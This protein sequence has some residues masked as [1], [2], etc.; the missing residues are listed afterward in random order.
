[1]RPRRGPEPPALAR[2]LLALSAEAGSREAQLGDAHEEF[3]ERAARSVAEARRWYWR[4]ALGSVAPNVG[5]RARRRTTRT[6]T[7]KGDGTMTSLVRNLRFAL[8]AARK[9]AAFSAV[10]VATLALGIGANTTVFSAVYGLILNPFPFPEPDR[11]VG[12][13]TAYPRLGR[14]LGFFENLSPAEWLDVRDNTRTLEDVVAWDMGNRQIAGDGPPQNVFTGFWWGDALRTLEMRPHLGRGFT[15]EELFRGDQVALLSHRIWRDRFGADSTLVG[16]TL[17][18]NGNPHTLIGILPEGVVLYGMDLWTIMPVGPQVYP[19]NRRQMQV[20][21][22]I[23]DGVSL[24]EVNTE[25]EG[26]A[27]RVQMA[28]AGEFEEYEGWSIRAVRW[29]EVASQTF[30]TGAFVLLGAVA[31]VLLLV[32]ANTANLLLARAQG[33]RREMAVRTAMGAG[34]GTLLGQLLTES[35]VLAG[36]GGAVG[37]GLAFV[38]NEGLRALMATLALPIAGSV[39][40][41]GPV[42]AF[43]AAVAVGAGVLFGLVPAFQ[44]SRGDIAGILQAEGKGAT[45]GASRQR[46]QRV[47]VGVEVALAF[48]LL[49][50]GGLLVNSFVRLNRV[51]PGFDHE[52]LLSMR[53]TLPREEYQGDAVPAFFRELAER[54]EGVPGV[55]S[56]AAGTQFPPIGFAQSELWFEGGAPSEDATLPRALTTVV[57]RGYFETLGIPLRAGR[58]FGA[59]DAADTPPVAVIN[60]AA[61]R[62]YYPDGNAVGKR[63]KLGGPD[64][65]APWFEIVGVVGATQ[66]R[67]LDRAAEPEIFGLHDQLGGNQN[68]LFLLLRTDVEPASVLPDVRAAVAEMDADQPIYAIQTVEEAFASSISTRRAVTLFLTVFGVFALVLAAVGIYAVVSFTV[69]ERTQEI[70]LRVALGADGG[71]VR[72]LVVGQALLP[73]AIGAAVGVGLSIPLGAGLQR[74]LFQISGR[75]P[76]T[77]GSVAALLVGVAAVASLV[78]AWRASRLDPVEA[79]RRE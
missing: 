7:P 37:I 25:M 74:L 50:G 17:L 18:I 32:C 45:A 78:P 9:N 40:I 56:A 10:V 36:L 64:S 3:E 27:R 23:R 77:L 47:F 75:D 4:Q 42:L 53:L 60:E 5:H 1:M 69:S 66:N 51:D 39:E 38:G 49:A 44:G 79:L 58:T 68:Q 31:F 41:N 72:R 2:L 34:R 67:G 62:R 76:L 35:L 70:G 63:L 55:R 21:A 61:A 11:I 54:M 33:R 12:V 13:G 24:Q 59:A 57:T 46:M 26:I 48:V 29:N 22:R 71:R 73:V 43:T 20:I 8:R 30:R 65:E 19:R 52:N 15:D 28:H 14:D 6:R 16:S